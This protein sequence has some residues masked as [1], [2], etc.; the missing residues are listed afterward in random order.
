MSRE[1][2]ARTRIENAR[3]NLSR[4]NKR[5]INYLRFRLESEVIKADPWLMRQIERHLLFLLTQERDLQNQKAVG[6]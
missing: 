2:A 4:A 6:Q 5:Y 1:L 3:T